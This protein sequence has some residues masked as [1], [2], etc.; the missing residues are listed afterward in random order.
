MPR[1]EGSSAPSPTAMK[2]PVSVTD[3]RACN[4]HAGAMSWR[5]ADDNM[6]Q[7]DSTVTV[8]YR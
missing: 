2:N 7:G 1:D 4:G 8:G 6:P 5:K 3:V